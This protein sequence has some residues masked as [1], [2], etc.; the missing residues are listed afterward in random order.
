MLLGAGLDVTL[1]GGRE[2]EV[3]GVPILTGTPN[4]EDI[5]TV[6]MYL[7]AGRQVAYEDYLI[8]TVK[9]ARI[10]FNP[11]AENINFALKAKAERIEVVNACTLVMIATD[12]YV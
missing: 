5:H 4:L 7:G 10:I 9:P 1:I 3:E 6:T 11:G 2:G 8:Q 12:Q